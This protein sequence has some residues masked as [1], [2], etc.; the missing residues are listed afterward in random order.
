VERDR[1]E[2]GKRRSH[3]WDPRFYSKGVEK[4]VIQASS[5]AAIWAAESS[6]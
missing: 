5:S 2:K 3:G 4:L 6:A 1:K